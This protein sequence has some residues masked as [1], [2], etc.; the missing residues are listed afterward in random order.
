MIGSD[1]HVHTSFSSDSDT[2]MEAMI[3]RGIELGLSSICFTDHIDYGF[4]AQKYGMDFLY[5]MDD[6][7]AA[8]QNLSAKYPEISLRTGVELGLKSDIL[9]L[10]TSLSKTY[11]FDFIIGSTHLVDNIDP[12]YPEYWEAYGEESG[13]RHYYEV[14]YENICQGFDFDVY[15]HIDYVIRYC[16]TVKK[17]KYLGKI[18]ENYYHKMMKVNWDIINEIL[19][20]LI[21]LNKGIELNTGGLKYGLNHPNP[22]EKILQQYH[23]LGG[24]ILTIG[25]DAHDTI[26]LAYDFNLIPAILKKCGFSSYT[27]FKERKP[28]QILLE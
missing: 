28:T 21:S 9:S 27:E 19:S 23:E 3:Q 26:H 17:A 6:Y 4:P 11:P 2:P 12:Y 7:F 24:E 14:T 5:S 1:N 10:A 20:R 8:I 15:G 22:H 13:I 25:S 16:P 18:D